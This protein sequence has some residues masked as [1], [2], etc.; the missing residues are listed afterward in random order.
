MSKLEKTKVLQGVTGGIAAFKAAALTSRLRQAGA[1]VR[2]I[3]TT[4]AQRFVTS[5][6]FEALSGNP[7]C[8]NM[9]QIAQ[10]HVEHVALADWAQVVVVAPATA[11]LLAKVAHGLCDDLLSTTLCATTAPVLFAPAMTT[12]MWRNPI[13][14]RNVAFLREAGYRFVDPAEGWLA[15]DK[16]G[17]GRMAEP[18][19]IV[20]QLEQLI[21]C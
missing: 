13:T 8:S 7:V 2:V 9:W 19:E 18:E 15:C 20:R 3:L 10:Q 6:T 12:N 14:Q 1:E 21:I 4:N 16:T 17:P 11:N 5:L